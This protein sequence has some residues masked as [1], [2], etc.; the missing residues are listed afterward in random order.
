MYEPSL[1]GQSI[2][3][4]GM[5]PAFPAGNGRCNRRKKKWGQNYFCPQS[6]G[7]RALPL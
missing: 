1:A 7:S 2:A 5:L 3:V 6:I 4:A